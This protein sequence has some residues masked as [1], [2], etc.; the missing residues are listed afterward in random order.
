MKRDSPGPSGSEPPRKRPL[1][2]DA[3]GKPRFK[4]CDGIKAYE[5]ICKL[6]EGTFGEVHKAR[7]RATGSMVALKKILMHNAKEEGFP[8]TALREIKILKMLSHKNIVR[9]MEMAVERK[10]VIGR[11]TLYMVTPYMDHDLAGL[12]ENPDVTFTE[13]Q[14][15]CYML[16]LLEGTKYLHEN[17][18]LHRDMKAANLLIDNRGILQIADFGLARKFEE[19]IPVAG[20]GGGNPGRDYTNCVV[21]RWYR[22]PEL[23]L[24]ERAY[25]SAI[26]LWGVGCV[27]AEMY[28]GKPILQGNSDM[29]QLM[30]IFQ[31]CGSPN[32][33]NMPGFE[34]LPGCEGF[35]QFGPYHR[36]LEGHYSE[37]GSAGVSLLSEFLRLDPRKRINAIDAL[38]HEYFTTDPQP[39]KPSD[40]PRFEDSHELDRKKFRSRANLPPAPAGG[41][42]GVTHNPAGGEWV[43]RAGEVPWTNGSG[44][45]AQGRR[46]DGQWNNGSA[47]HGGGR[48][49]DNRPLQS[50]DSRIPQ[51]QGQG[52]RPPGPDHRPAWTRGP[53]QSDSGHRELGIGLPPRPPQP[54]MDR[55]RGGPGNN[56]GGGG[57]GGG[58]GS[59]DTYIPSY[60]GGGGV[61]DRRGGGNSRG[62]WDRDNRGVSRER[63]DWRDSRGTHMERGFSG[64][65]GG[66]QRR[67]SSRDRHRD[68]GEPVQNNIYRR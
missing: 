32:E 48:Q 53:P 7:H 1:T 26:D 17:K 46:P 50:H 33:K 58:G 27:F 62:G 10:R 41:T 51:G 57:G 9:L 24:G 44:G 56:R 2:V 67:S 64:S 14:I 61:D 35:R 42:V 60:G 59:V 34:K 8:I 55:H 63:A 20:G 21:T 31:L 22:P 45:P 6:G 54:H 43:G 38:K 68:G 40:L 19:E 11:G 23:L 66:G 47:R 13:P 49:H 5:I 36:A 29:D 37:M 39:A 28:K 12:L 25:T 18:I 52:H 15:K 30:K 4:G 65:T 16:Q 3:N